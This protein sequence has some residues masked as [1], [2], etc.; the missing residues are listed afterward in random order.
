MPGL[1]P[2][3]SPEPLPRTALS[4]HQLTAK[5]VTEEISIT[6]EEEEMS[7]DEDGCGLG[8]ISAASEQNEDVSP[9]TYKY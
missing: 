7:P 3:L 1:P 2:F 4:N 9:E 8:F 6:N 5:T